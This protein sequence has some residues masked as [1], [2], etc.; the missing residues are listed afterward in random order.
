MPIH[1]EAPSASTRRFA[2]PDIG[3]LWYRISSAHSCGASPS[4][5]Q[6]YAT[7]KSRCRIARSSYA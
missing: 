4:T 7:L 2:V 3:S 6:G 5:S 1:P